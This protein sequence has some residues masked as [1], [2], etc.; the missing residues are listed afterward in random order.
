MRDKMR[1]LV[2]LV[3]GVALLGQ[4]GCATTQAPP[5][6]DVSGK[7]QGDWVGLVLGEG[8]GQIQ[9]DVK[10]SGSRFSGNVLVTGRSN[11]P[12]GLTEGYVTGNQ[13]E[14]TVPAGVTGTLT[15]K[16][17]EMSGTI[18]GMS[19]AKVTLRRQK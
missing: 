8:A 9:M 4:A 18:A 12:S 17:D 19:G 11:D 13:V 1:R 15:V 14:I 6:V 5:T 16:G 7:W 10:Q 3:V 2:W